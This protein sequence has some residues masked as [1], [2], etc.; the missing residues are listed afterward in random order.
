MEYTGCG[1][2]EHRGL[3]ARVE[4]CPD[5]HLAQ[6]SLRKYAG[7]RKLKRACHTQ[8]LGKNAQLQQ[9]LFFTYCDVN[10]EC[11]AMSELCVDPLWYGEQPIATA[12]YFF[13]K[14]FKALKYSIN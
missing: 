9:P 14:K 11:Q 8:D 2:S 13:K 1:N 5:C 3:N 4:Y 10:H 12:K 7:S 6:I